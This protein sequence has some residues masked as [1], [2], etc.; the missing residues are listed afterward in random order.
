MPLTADRPKPMIALAGKPILERILGQLRDA[1]IDEAIIVHGYL[2]ET[3]E[4]YFGDG[5]RIGMRVTY[6]RQQDLTGTAGAMLLAEDL[7]GDEPF[8]LHWGDILVDPRN[9]REVLATFD[10]ERAQC[11]TNVIW[12]EDPW[13]GG[14]VYRDASRV[15]RAIEKPP[16]G[17]GHTHWIIG[18]VIAFAPCLWRYLHETE[19]PDHGEFFVTQAIDLMAQRGETV[20][21]HETIGKRLHITSP[22]DVAA[23]QEDPRLAAWES[24]AVR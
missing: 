19:P 10:A 13:A 3:I 5:G 7:C 17:T 1:G 21:A 15:L 16:R 24:A 23:L 2:G 18:G 12:V 22:E 14:A 8:L 6:R 9:I 20:L 4:E 11:V